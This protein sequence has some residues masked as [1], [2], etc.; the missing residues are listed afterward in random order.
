MQRLFYKPG[1][2]VCFVLLRW[3]E[4]F[5]IGLPEV[6]GLAAGHASF[7]SAASHEDGVAV[8]VVVATKGLG[9]FRRVKESDGARTIQVLL[10][11]AAL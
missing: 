5:Y 7:R 9:D 10:I 3:L 1:V 4:D 2:P 11:G 8:D 6:V